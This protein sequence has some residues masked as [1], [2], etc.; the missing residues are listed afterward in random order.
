MSA[1]RGRTSGPRRWEYFWWASQLGIFGL[2]FESVLSGDMRKKTAR[3][4]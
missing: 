4:L 3:A 2:I 1:L